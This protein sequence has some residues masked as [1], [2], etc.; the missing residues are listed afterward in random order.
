MEA[1]FSVGG[2][3]KSHS[4]ANG[5]GQGP[6]RSPVAHARADGCYLPGQT[7]QRGRRVDASGYT[8]AVGWKHWISVVVLVV[9]AAVPTSG[10]LC[11]LACGSSAETSSAHHGRATKQCDEPAPSSAGVHL[12]DVSQHNCSAHGGPVPQVATAAAERTGVHVA[13][14]LAVTPNRYPTFDSVPTN[15]PSFEYTSPPSWAPPTIPLVLRV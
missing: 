5:A 6:L 7:T 1:A 2:R 4:T 10:V 13:H 15:A 12:E 8:R 9:L 3:M 14:V 11:A